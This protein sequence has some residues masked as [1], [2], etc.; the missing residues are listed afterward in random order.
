MHGGTY[1][2]SMRK[3]ALQGG[4]GE[5]DGMRETKSYGIYVDICGTHTM[6][7]PVILLQITCT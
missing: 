1:S 6:L 2:F 3:I 4:H 5:N 7:G